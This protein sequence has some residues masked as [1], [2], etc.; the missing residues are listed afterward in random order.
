MNNTHQEVQCKNDIKNK[1]IRS[2]NYSISLIEIIRIDE[3]AQH[4]FWAQVKFFPDGRTLKF[5]EV[6]YN[7]TNKIYG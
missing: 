5:L 2:G 4:R 6:K 7:P 3:Q 1:I